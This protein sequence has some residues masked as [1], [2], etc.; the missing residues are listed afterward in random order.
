MQTLSKH[1]HQKTMGIQLSLL[2]KQLVATMQCIDNAVE[3]SEALAL[4]GNMDLSN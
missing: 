2:K 3:M 4:D 1:K